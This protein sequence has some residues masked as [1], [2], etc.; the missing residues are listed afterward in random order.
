MRTIHIT[1]YSQRHLP[2][3]TFLHQATRE[4]IFDAMREMAKMVKE[5][6]ADS[7]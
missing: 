2:G 1:E 7:R 5:F 6:K 3:N 4:G